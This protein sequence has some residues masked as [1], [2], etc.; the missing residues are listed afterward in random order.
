MTSGRQTL[1][2]IDNAVAQARAN[3]ERTS[4]LAS[5]MAEERAAL[6][7]RRL[8]AIAIIAAERMAA[9]EAGDAAAP[10]DRD[11]RRA[12]QEARALLERYA[13]EI[14]GLREKA[15]TTQAEL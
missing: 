10:R 14:A 4:E 5:Q 3:L 7:Q 9:L 1:H 15:K 2:D 8:E 13:D 11:V 6:R 12:D